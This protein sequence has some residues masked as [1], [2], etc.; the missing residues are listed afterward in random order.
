MS[1]YPSTAVVDFNMSRETV[2]LHLTNANSGLSLLFATLCIVDIFG[3]FPIITLPRA[4]IQCGLY[5]IPLVL[6][7]FGLQI[8]TA[9]LLG[10]S[11]TIA[12]ILD[13]QISRKNRYPLAAVTE[14]TMG[15]RA[16]SIVT[17][18]MDLTVFGCGIPNLL[19]A[20]QNLQLFAL[21][22]SGQHFDLSFCY[23]LLIIGVLLCPL[24]WLGS[25]RDMKWVATCS[26]V[27]VVLTTILIWWSIIIDDR[28]FDAAPITT[29]PTWNKFLSGYGM[30]AFQFDV[31]PTLMTIQ[32]DMRQPQNIDKAIFFSFITSGSMFVVTVSLVAWKYSDDTTAN[33]LEA[34]PPGLAA[35][36]AVLLAALQLCFSS[37]IGY[38][39][40]FQHLE[41]HWSI[42]RTFGWKR[43][44]TRSAVVLLSV[45]IGESISRFDIIMTLIGGSLTGSLVFLLPPV[46]YNRALTL[47]KSTQAIATTEWVYPSARKRFRGKEQRSMPPG[48][49]SHSTYYGFLNTTNNPH[50]YTYLYFDNLDDKINSESSESEGEQRGK[51]KKTTD[52]SRSQQENQPLLS[53]ATKSTRIHTQTLT[54]DLQNDMTVKRKR[55]WDSERAIN[56]F[57]YF[58]VA[59]GIAITLSSTYINILNTIRYVRFTP[60]CIVNATTDISVS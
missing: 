10:K 41:D 32:V 9:I 51:K 47:K 58:I 20:S 53:D 35:N 31:H 21:K 4:I 55:L 11:W 29:S 52:T 33:I 3:V 8:Y 43:C 42:E 48:A 16:R 17:L 49:H 28:I 46:M 37:V 44:A 5:G 34:V 19:V 27:T 30:L 14:L 25:P 60:P 57:G 23:W 26:S 18:L 2:P 22:L 15:S 12:N 45:A 38:S 56:Y 59:I 7:V 54:S 13:P 40:L 36:V 24:M 50:S 39:A 6:V 1:R